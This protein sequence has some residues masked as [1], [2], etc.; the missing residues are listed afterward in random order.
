MLRYPLCFLPGEGEAGRVALPRGDGG[1]GHQHL[2]GRKILPSLGGIQANPPL[3]DLQH[4]LCAGAAPERRRPVA[5]LEPSQALELRHHLPGEPD[6]GGSAVHV[7]AALPHRHLLPGGHLALRG[8]L[9]KLVRFL[10]YANLPCSMLLLAGISVHRFLAARHPLRSL[11]TGPA[12]MPCWAPPPRGHWWASSGCPPWSS[13]ARTTS[14]ASWS[15]TTR[16]ARSASTSFSS[17][18]WC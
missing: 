7:D 13:P 10:L 4:H 3:P 15:A 11:P 5:L 18:A 17:T 9:C 12:G 8:L 6:G 2:S 16:P 14:T 1:A